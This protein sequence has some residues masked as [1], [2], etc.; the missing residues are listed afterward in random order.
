MLKGKI[1]RGD[2]VALDPFANTVAIF[3][4]TGRQ[5]RKI[6]ARYAPAVS[7]VRYRLEN[8]ELIE[9]LVNGEPLQ[10]SRRYTGATNS[11]FAGR[12]FRG[13]RARFQDTGKQR[14]EVL[15]NY[16]RRKGTIR[17]VYDKRRVVIGGPSLKPQ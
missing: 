15:I 13:A 1:T 3:Q 9:V 10:D 17:P 16:I 2:L 11:Y 6:L 7:G 8:G 4:I 12:A 14:L 5:L